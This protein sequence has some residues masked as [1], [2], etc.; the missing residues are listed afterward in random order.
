MRT[1]AVKQSTPPYQ[2]LAKT[3]SAQSVFTRDTVTGTLLSYYAPQIFDGV[4]VA[5][6]HSHFLSA[7]H[8]FGG[9]VLDFATVSGR[10]RFQQFDSLEQ[11]LP[12]TNAAYMAHDFTQDH[13]LEDIHQ[14][15]N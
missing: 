15:E 1:R 11:H 9:H 2:S 12:T 4:A 10:V 8:D 6:Y 3:A 7:A 5:G 14:S 13:I